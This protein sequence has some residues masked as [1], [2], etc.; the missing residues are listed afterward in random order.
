[1]IEG[2]AWLIRD[3]LRHWRDGRLTPEAAIY[4][5]G[6][7]LG[8]DPDLIRN[9]MLAEKRGPGGAWNM[10]LQALQDRAERYRQRAMNAEHKAA[11]GSDPFRREM[12]DVAAQWQDLAR[13]AQALD[14][15][16]MGRLLADGTPV[17]SRKASGG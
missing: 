13:Q 14:D 10:S 2:K 3:T 11:L 5:V 4:R 17:E 8:L 9:R 6:E 1:V 7:A 15:I 16:A 12:M